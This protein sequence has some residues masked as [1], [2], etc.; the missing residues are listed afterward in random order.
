M[1]AKD[2]EGKFFVEQDVNAVM[3]E[4][5]PLCE[6]IL[7]EETFDRAEVEGRRGE[8]YEMKEEG[9]EKKDATE[10]CMCTRTAGWGGQKCGNTSL[11]M[12]MGVELK[13]RSAIFSYHL[14]FD[15]WVLSYVLKKLSTF[16]EGDERVIV[17]GDD[18]P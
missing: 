3:V 13:D 2:E 8:A 12:W 15:N 11:E 9:G 10:A 5:R 1:Q 14:L 4:K 7:T 6:I 18:P 16:M 17:A